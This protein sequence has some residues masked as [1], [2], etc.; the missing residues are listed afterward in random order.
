LL[1]AMA[2]VLAHGPPNAAA[3]TAPLAVA[4]VFLV[5]WVTADDLL[6][7]A[8]LRWLGLPSPPLDEDERRRGRRKLRWFAVGYVVWLGLLVVAGLATAGYFGLTP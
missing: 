8:P 2:V 7:A 5:R 4:A 1:A 3:A 6:R